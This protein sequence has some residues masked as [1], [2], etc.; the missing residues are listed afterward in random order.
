MAVERG[1]SRNTI[2]AYRRDLAEFAAHCASLGVSFP[3]DVSAP[4]VESFLAARESVG[5]SVA[6][7]ARRLAAV[8]T[9]FAY[10]CEEGRLDSNPVV[11]VD[12]VRVP[13]GVPRPLSLDETERLLAA[14]RGDDALERRNRAL[15]EMLYAT[16]ARVTEMCGLDM[17]DLDVAGR[18][19]RLCGKGNKERVVPFGEHASRA[20]DDWLSTG[21]R[22]ILLGRG[23]GVGGGVG[24]VDAVFLGSR[25]GRL[26]RQ[27][28]HAVIREGGRRAGLGNDLSP[29]TLRH[30]CATH[31]L[32]HGA[33]LRVVQ[34]ML[35]HASIST[36][37]IY[38]RVS[39]ERMFAVYRDAHPRARR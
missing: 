28:A 25:G 9:L 23:G 31:L 10:L 2:G 4:V 27:A 39:T 24:G 8:R 14:F 18:M 5:E 19:V 30:T 29:H 21:G 22:E 13:G 16:G 36:T 11:V 12:G 15:V 20:L 1:R 33:D 37:Q 17:Q 35:G 7:R 38:T 34:E 26:A 6:T 32:D 3:D